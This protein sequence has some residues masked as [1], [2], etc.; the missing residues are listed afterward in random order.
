MSYLSSSRVSSY[1]SELDLDRCEEEESDEEDAFISFTTTESKCEQLYEEGLQSKCEGDL[2]ES[3]SSFLKCLE[4][5]QECQY[6]S[7]LPQTLHQLSDLYLSLQ[8]RE[9]AEAYSKAEKLFYEALITEPQAGKEGEPRPKTKRRPFGK[10]PRP[11]SSSAV[12][13][14]AEY[15]NLLNKKAEVFERLARACAAECKFDLAQEHS[16]KAASIRQTVLGQRCRSSSDYVL[17]SRA[18][19]VVGGHMYTSLLKGD[20]SKVDTVCDNESTFFGGA[21]VSMSHTT[22]TNEALYPPQYPPHS[23]PQTENTFSHRGSVATIPFEGATTRPCEVM[24]DKRVVPLCSMELEHTPT[25]EG[26]KYHMPV[27]QECAHAAIQRDPRQEGIH[28]DRVGREIRSYQEVNLCA[29][30]TNNLSKPMFKLSDF[31]NPMCKLSNPMSKLSELKKPMSKLSELKNP[32]CV[33]LDLH[34]GP[35]EGVEPTRC[36]P[37]WILLLP[38]FLALLG[39]LMYYH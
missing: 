15:G 28:E 16:S 2:R 36:L 33:N 38:G 20:L 11:A 29:G 17:Y 39:Y 25:L 19:P 10:K 13:N 22:V 12:C 14:P 24:S 35:G 31:K 3:L 26:Y 37:L 34:K 18:V 7:K 21:Q 32:M 23:S 4:G 6:F 9:R 27:S 1:Y 30:V 8:L 5:M